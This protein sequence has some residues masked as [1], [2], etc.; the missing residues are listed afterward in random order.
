MDPLASRYSTGQ[1]LK[2]AGVTNAVL[3]TWIRRE[4]IVGQHPNEPAVDMPGKAGHRRTFSFYAVMQ[5]A[6]AK[7]IID[8]SG[9]AARAFEAAMEFAHLGDEQRSPGVP[10]RDGRT[11][12]LVSEGAECLVQASW[13][14]D[15][16]AL[17]QWPRGQRPDAILAVDV[18]A[19]F[20]RA[21]AAIGVNPQAVIEANTGD[22]S[23]GW[24]SGE[25]IE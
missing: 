20:D 8:V 10:F 11:W 6:V 21:C 23:D 16:F 1:V 12:L 25:I 9:K 5:I 15:P 3:Q 13:G 17:A 24:G 14:T 22:A 7:A 19:I 2:A 4:F 18:S